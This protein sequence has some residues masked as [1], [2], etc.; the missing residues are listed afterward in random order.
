MLDVGRR[1]LPARAPPAS[2]SS[3]RPDCGDQDRTAPTPSVD[4][5]CRRGPTR[6]AAG[7]P[8]CPPTPRSSWCTT[9]PG[10][11]PRRA[12]RRRARGGGRR[13]AST[14]P[15]PA[16]PLSDTIKVVDESSHVTSTLD[17]SALVAVQTPQ[18]FRADVLRRAHERRGARRPPTTPCW[19]RR[20]GA[21]RARGARRRR[22]PQDHHPRRPGDRRAPAR[23]GGGDERA[24]RPG[25]RHPSLLRGPAP[26]ARA[27]RRRDR[28]GPRA[29]RPQRR[30]R[31]VPR[32]GRRRP[33]RRRPGRPRPALPRHGPGRGRGPTAW[34]C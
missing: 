10:R 18:A 30:R 1:G 13:R 32:A 21:T 31:G 14:E 16:S 20:S 17:R 7:S 6:S 12:L 9:R 5:R 2:S 3:S 24:R 26:P 22:Q 27:R 11:W 4:R 29:R 15:Y 8:P 34:R 33:R 25:D 23:R 28:G 19:S